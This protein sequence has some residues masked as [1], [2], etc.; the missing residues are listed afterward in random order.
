MLDIVA[1]RNEELLQES[2]KYTGKWV[3][4]KKVKITDDEKNLLILEK[5]RKM[6]NF[7]QDKD[8][9]SEAETDL[10]FDLVNGNIERDYDS[11]DVVVK[12]M[13]KLIKRGFSF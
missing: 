6:L 5:I 11:D 4:M 9:L 10:L 7:N 12:C 1:I 13:Q 3:Q 2:E 8:I